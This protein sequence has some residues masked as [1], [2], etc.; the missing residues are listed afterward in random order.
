M[1][2]LSVFWRNV[3]ITADGSLR[4]AGDLHLVR[5]HSK[6]LDGNLRTDSNIFV[7]CHRRRNN[8][9]RV[10]TKENYKTLLRRVCDRFV[11]A[12]L[13]NKST[14]SRRKCSLGFTQWDII[15][16]FVQSL[17][18]SDYSY[19]KAAYMHAQGRIQRGFTGC[20]WAPPLRIKQEK[21]L[22]GIKSK[23]VHNWICTQAAKENET[24]RYFAIIICSQNYM[25]VLYYFF[26][27]KKFLWTLLLLELVL[28]VAYLIDA[29]FRLFCLRYPLWSYR[30]Y[31]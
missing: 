31:G 24:C 6:S 4:V 11:Y 28:S 13:Y 5:Q 17:H 21:F 9:D 3:D 30:F 10:S 23:N 26:V 29:Y 2:I 27:H 12:T 7:R 1:Y 22:L 16:N 25:W 19:T 15:V 8:I 18:Q 14:T 20:P